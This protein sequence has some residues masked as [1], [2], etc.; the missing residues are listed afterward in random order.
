MNY[1]EFEK[2]I[3]RKFAKKRIPLRGNFELTG[4][5]NFNCK[6]C[7]VHTKPNSEF[8]KTERDGKWWV[9]QIDAA[10]DRGMLFALLT[11]GECL[12]HPDFKEIYLHLRSKGVYTYINTNGFLLTPN[13]VEFLSQNPPMEIQITL[14]GSDNDS[15]EKVTGVRAFDQVDAAIS[16]VLEAGLNIRI[17]I[18]P[19]AYAPEDAVKIIEYCKER[20][21]SY[22][23][24]QAMFTPY[25]QEEVQKISDNEVDVDMQIQYYKAMRGH[26]IVDTSDIVLPK[27]G[28]D[29]CEPVQGLRC[30]AGTTSF[31]ITADGYMQPCYSMHHL[32]VPIQTTA[33]FGTTWEQMLKISSEYLIP[34]ECE[35]CAYRKACFV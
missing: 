11:G 9:A 17:A 1:M 21:V 2:E 6:M 8:L 12:M 34:V 3:T 19:N 16:R 24:N 23:I 20:N 31:M 27:V 4:R 22:S 26:D 5:C 25:D 13:N 10:C 18:T 15:Y 33:D 29:K 32:R 28:G 35:G 30:S 7:Y 14:Y